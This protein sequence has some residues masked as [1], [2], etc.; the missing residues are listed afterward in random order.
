MNGIITE[1]WGMR[2]ETEIGNVYVTDDGNPGSAQNGW[3]TSDKFKIHRTEHHVDG[4]WWINTHDDWVYA[5][6]EGG[7]NNYIS[8]RN[9]IMIPGQKKIHMD[10]N[11][12]KREESDNRPTQ[13]ALKIVMP[14]LMRVLEEYNHDSRRAALALRRKEY[15]NRNRLQER[16]ETLQQQLVEAKT[17]LA[18]LIEQYQVTYEELEARFSVAQ[19]RGL[20][21]ALADIQEHGTVA[22]VMNRYEKQHGEGK[23]RVLL[24]SR[25]AM[26]IDLADAE[27]WVE[28]LTYLNELSDHYHGVN[29]VL[30]L[31]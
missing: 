22:A 9:Y 21:R 30:D 31:L 4:R 3:I 17:E 18:K 23:S 16:I 13:A 7:H 5:D 26:P 2:Y 29:K 10:W 12:I 28:Q 8:R 25:R 14:L 20:T 15:L 11:V 27:P 19:D 24:G 1:E 6:N